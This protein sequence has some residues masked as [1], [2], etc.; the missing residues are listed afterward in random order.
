MNA[1]VTGGTGFLGRALLKLLIPQT[2]A[3]RVLVRRPE[4][5]ASIPGMVP[6]ELAV[7]LISP[8]EFVARSAKVL[9]LKSL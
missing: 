3:V 1:T 8:L 6:R 5:D 9:R 4:D 7:D 2:R